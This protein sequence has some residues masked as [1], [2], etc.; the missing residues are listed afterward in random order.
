M[1]CHYVPSRYSNGWLL[2]S[3]LCRA[4]ENLAPD[5]N[6]VTRTRSF[7]G[8][9]MNYKRKAW[10]VSLVVVEIRFFGIRAWNFSFTIAL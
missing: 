1:K 5:R 7:L 10:L 9:S 6:K 3:E 8:W 4:K 2:F